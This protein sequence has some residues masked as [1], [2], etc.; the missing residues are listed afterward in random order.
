MAPIYSHSRLSTFENCPKQFR[1]RYVDQIP[2]ETEGI[3]AFVGKRVHELMERLYMFVDRG[4]VPS[5]EQVIDRYRALWDETF[6]AER[7]RIVKTDTSIDLYHELGIRCIR[8]YYRRHYPF[9]GDET[10]GLE[11]RVVF[12]LDEAGEYRMQGIIDRVVR[13]RDG[14]VEIQD[15]KTGQW[16]P[17]QA[18]LDKERQLALYQIGYCDTENDDSPV[19][20]VWHYLAR[21]QTRTSTRTNRSALPSQAPTHFGERGPGVRRPRYRVRGAEK[22]GPAR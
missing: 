17:S 11:R 21:G 3:E 10:L 15:Y 7:V 22:C 20:L 2:A 18:K 5:V 19:R 9:D 6:D 12:D 16:V 14:A 4:Q 8:N 13:S 1:F